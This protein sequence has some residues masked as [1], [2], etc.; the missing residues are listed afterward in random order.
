M[1]IGRQARRGAARPTAQRAPARCCGERASQSRA[2]P[3]PPRRRAHAPGALQDRPGPR[4][5]ARACEEQMS[6]HTLRHTLRHA[7]ARRRLRPALA[8][9]D[10]RPRRPRD[11]AGLHA[12]LGRA[13]QGRV[14]QRASA[15]LAHERRVAVASTRHPR[16]HAAMNGSR[17][18]AAARRA[19]VL[20][21]DACGVGALPDAAD[22]GDEGTNTLA[23]V[24]EAVGGLRAADAAGARARL[25]P[26]RCAACRRAPTR[27]STA[28]CTRSGRARTRS[29][30]TGS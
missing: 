29:P 13:P 18:P 24:A 22:Y 10:A 2:V 14:L 30:G 15:R 3:Q 9:G 23:H 4:A 1:P 8:A 20:V 16:R 11:H 25:D 6:P 27:R 28:A 21:I 5:R 17:L 19:F 7:P 26:R 12:P